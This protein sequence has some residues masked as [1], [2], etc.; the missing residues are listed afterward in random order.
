MN[1]DALKEENLKLQN[2]V[3]KLER[4]LLK[5]GQKSIHLDQY[6]RRN[7]REIQDIPANVTDDELEVK[8]IDIF[9]CLAI[10]VKGADIEDCHTLGYANLENTI[11]RFV[12]HKFCYL[13]LVKKLELHKLDSKSLGFNPVKALYFSEN[14]TPLNQLLTWKCRELKRTS[15]IHSTWIVWGVIRI[16]RN[17]NCPIN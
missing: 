3:K 6:N 9:S 1:I 2:K 17:A 10:K 16:R 11:V 14:L 13:A 5:T 8:V 7:N 4:Q 15:I 12:H